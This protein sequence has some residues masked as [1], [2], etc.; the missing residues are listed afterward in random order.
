MNTLLSYA[1]SLTCKETFRPCSSY[2]NASRG[3]YEFLVSRVARAMGA[4]K[5]KLANGSTGYHAD[6]TRAS[7]ARPSAL[8]TIAERERFAVR[9]L[10]ENK[11]RCPDT[12]KAE[13]EEALVVARKAGVATV[14]EKTSTAPKVADSEPVRVYTVRARF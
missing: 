12:L 2:S 1:D 7:A 5:Y 10:D 6:G 9:W 14:A 8:F 13:L 3:A 11:G 4:A